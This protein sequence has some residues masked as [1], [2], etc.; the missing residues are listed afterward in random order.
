M[1]RHT[2]KLPLATTILCVLLPNLPEFRAAH[3]IRIA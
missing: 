1:W 3:A 2:G